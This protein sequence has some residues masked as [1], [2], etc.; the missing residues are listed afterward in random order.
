MIEA[1]SPRQQVAQNL[2]DTCVFG[3]LN[4]VY[5]VSVDRQEQKGKKF[6]GITFCKAR[7]LD[8]HISVYSPNFILIRWQTKF[9]HLPAAGQEVFKSEDAAKQFLI[10]NFVQQ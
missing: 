6:W 7:V 4:E 2:A 1:M 5:G 3:G 10:K 9:R 8:G